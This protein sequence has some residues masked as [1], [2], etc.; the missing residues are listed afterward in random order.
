MR[1]SFSAPVA[2]VT[3]ATRSLPVSFLVAFT[4]S[5]LSPLPLEVLRV[6]QSLSTD[7]CQLPTV[8]TSSSK[9]AASAVRVFSSGEIT[10]AALLAD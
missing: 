1:F 2:K 9:E 4:V 5:W 6:S 8:I 10:S 7:A 3:I